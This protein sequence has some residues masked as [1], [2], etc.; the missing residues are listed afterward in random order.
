M[1]L[2][3]DFSTN[4][5]SI[6]SVVTNSGIYSDI[7]S[8]YDNSMIDKKTYENILISFHRNVLSESIQMAK[9][10]T[11]SLQEI[12]VDGTKYTLQQAQ[13]F[14]ALEKTKLVTAQVI[15]EGE[16]KLLLETQKDGFLDN[17][18]IKMVGEI[19]GLV[20]EIEA[21][22]LEN[23][24]ENWALLYSSLG[25]LAQIANEHPQVTTNITVPPAPNQ[26]P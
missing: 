3:A 2:P 11:I 16:R 21:G 6:L 12:E 8:M 10:L 18:V 13:I 14:E 26:V 9:E 25:A 4:L 23:P 5:T 19:R 1:V 15:T 7:K 17:R 22:G 24:T 20:G